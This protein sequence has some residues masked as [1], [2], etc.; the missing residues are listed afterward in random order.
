MKILR[1]YLQFNWILTSDWNE[2]AYIFVK[3]QVTEDLKNTK[4]CLLLKYNKWLQTFK[5]MGPHLMFDLIYILNHVRRLKRKFYTTNEYV[6]HKHSKKEIFNSRF[7]ASEK[8]RFSQRRN[9]LSAKSWNL[10]AL[11][12]VIWFLSFQNMRNF[13][14]SSRNNIWRDWINGLMGTGAIEISAKRS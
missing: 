9:F 1:A 4:I 3:W 14:I 10:Q 11:L 12:K 8:S 6:S 13:R 7:F 2:Y 5:F